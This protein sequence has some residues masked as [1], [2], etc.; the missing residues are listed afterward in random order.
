ML[1]FFQNVIENIFSEIILTN[2][3]NYL[4]MLKNIN[5]NTY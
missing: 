5:I 4:D 1:N 3:N 2:Y